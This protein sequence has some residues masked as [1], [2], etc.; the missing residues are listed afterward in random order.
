MSIKRPPNIP[1]LQEKKLSKGGEGVLKI[2]MGWTK[3][4]R[5]QK[6]CSPPV[7]GTAQQLPEALMVQHLEPRGLQGGAE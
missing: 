6:T 5:A 2:L 4:C 1:A 7:N 3:G